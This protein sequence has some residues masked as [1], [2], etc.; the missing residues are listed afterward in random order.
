MG[1]HSQIYTK[2]IGKSR[3]T[4]PRRG[5]VGSGELIELDELTFDVLRL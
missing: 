3:K 4:G 2:K 1:Q 5:G